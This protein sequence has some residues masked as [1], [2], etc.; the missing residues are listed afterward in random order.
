MSTDEEQIAAFQRRAEWHRLNHGDRADLIR[1]GIK[2]ENEMNQLLGNLKIVPDWQWIQ[3]KR[4]ARD[5]QQA[6][7]SGDR[8]WQT[9]AELRLDAIREMM[10]AST[11]PCGSP[12]SSTEAKAPRQSRAAASQGDPGLAVS[13]LVPT[14][15][16]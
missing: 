3:Y 5:A 16:R 12:S 9:R 11:L 2:Y 8:G 13:A 10:E 6:G 7:K 15:V 4:A 14:N 1:F